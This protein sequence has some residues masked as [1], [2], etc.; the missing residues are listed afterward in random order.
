M[1]MFCA[2]T[3]ILN[4]SK[5]GIRT[6]RGKALFICLLRSCLLRNCKGVSPSFHRR[7]LYVTTAMITIGKIV[8]FTK[9]SAFQI[10]I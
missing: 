3:L 5:N 2:I 9:A 6:L 1:G 8:V 10:V 7:I 4:L